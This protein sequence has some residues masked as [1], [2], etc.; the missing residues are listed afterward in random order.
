MRTLQE[1]DHLRD[2]AVLLRRQGKSLRQIKEVLG[3]MSNATLND[4]LKG[5]PPPR[6]GPGPATRSPGPGSRR[7][8]GAT[9]PLSIS[10]GKPREQPSAPLP[11]RSSGS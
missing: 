5:Q 1:L 7:E 6:T 11:R 10:P 3:P 4:A 2:Q 8:S 9:G